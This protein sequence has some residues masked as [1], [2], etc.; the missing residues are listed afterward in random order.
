MLITK[1]AVE[2]ADVLTVEVSGP[3]GPF[4]AGFVEDMRRQ[5]FGSVA[6]RKH[7]GLVAGLSGW[8]ASE[9]LAAPGLSSEVAERFCAARRANGH[10]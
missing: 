5:G 4:A 2:M 1:E 7:L 3:L 9:E 6:V 8:L 10:T